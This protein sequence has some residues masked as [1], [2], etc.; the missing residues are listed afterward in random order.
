MSFSFPTA[1]ACPSIVPIAPR[2]V[3]PGTV[4][5]VARIVPPRE[6]H[7]QH[8]THAERID[9]DDGGTSDLIIRST[10]HFAAQANSL[11]EREPVPESLVARI[12]AI[13]WVK[14]AW[15]AI[16]GYAELIDKQGKA[17]QAKGLPTVG[18]S[19][20]PDAISHSDQ[21]I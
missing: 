19:V 16:Q 7:I 18:S 10:A 9:A 13:P 3:T 6:S 20:T 12:A 17:I 4:R 15:A 14:A 21:T 5:H 11:P 2:P 1:I 8:A